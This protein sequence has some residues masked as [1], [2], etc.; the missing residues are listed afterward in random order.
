MGMSPAPSVQRMSFATV[1]DRLPGCFA[2]RMGPAVC[3]AERSVWPAAAVASMG[4]W[5]VVSSLHE[6]TT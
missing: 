5:G 4:W 6:G 3:Q 1:K 2:T